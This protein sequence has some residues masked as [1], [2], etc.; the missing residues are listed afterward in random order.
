MAGSSLP[1][2]TPTSTHY[3]LNFTT[4]PKDTPGWKAA[5][6]ALRDRILTAARTYVL[7]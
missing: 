1:S 2:L 6:T 3:E 5:D 7:H 4:L